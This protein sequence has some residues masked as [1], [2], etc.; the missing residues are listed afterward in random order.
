[1]C[2]NVIT[3]FHA[4]GYR[5]PNKCNSSASGKSLVKS[6]CHDIVLQFPVNRD[7]EKLMLYGKI[8]VYPLFEPRHVKNAQICFE[9][10]T[11]ASRRDCAKCSV[12]IR[13]RPYPLSCPEQKR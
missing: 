5:C 11:A 7:D 10:V 2:S 13:L 9:C 3:P 1:M 12:F 6:G 8:A 4:I